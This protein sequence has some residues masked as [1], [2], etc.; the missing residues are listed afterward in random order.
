MFSDLAFVLLGVWL[1]LGVAG[2]AHEV[3]AQRDVRASDES[4]R[5]V[6]ELEHPMFTV[7]PDGDMT[8]H[9]ATIVLGL[10]D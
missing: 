9:D 4:W 1:T 6:M 10:H 5:S 3:R 8:S 7:W 2:V